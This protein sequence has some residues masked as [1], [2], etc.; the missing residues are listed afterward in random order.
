MQIVE[1]NSFTRFQSFIIMNSPTTEEFSIP[2]APAISLPKGGGAIKN[3]GE[4]FQSN[5]LTGTATFEIP[6]KLSPGRGEFGPQLSLSYDS[7]NGNSVFGLGWDIGVLSITRKTQKGLPTYNDSKD[8]DTFIFSGA[9]DLV[10]YLKNENRKPSIRNEGEYEIHRYRP[11]TE[12]LFA[13]IER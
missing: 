1:L 13:K 8:S 12:G 5:P 6:I 10:P 2:Q 4:K 11:R 7:G 3:I 9:E